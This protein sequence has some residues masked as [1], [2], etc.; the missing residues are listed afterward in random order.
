M[1]FLFFKILPLYTYRAE[2]IGCRVAP[3]FLFSFSGAFGGGEVWSSPREK[4]EKKTLK[5]LYRRSMPLQ[6]N[7]ALLSLVSRSL[8]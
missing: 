6:T 3:L 7:R 5:P 2:G 1:S 4:F 8:A